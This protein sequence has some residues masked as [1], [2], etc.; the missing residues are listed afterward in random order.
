[1]DVVGFVE[2]GEGALLQP[3]VEF[4]LM[5]RGDDCCFFEEA[6]ELGFAEVGDADG[7]GFA[8]FQRRLHCFPGV[9]VVCIPGLYL[10]IFLGDQ[11]VAAREG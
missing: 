7:F 11:G 1:M 3:G 8:G 4:D 2:G 10:V 5:G 6:F 9:D